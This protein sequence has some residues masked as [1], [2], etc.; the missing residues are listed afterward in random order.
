[1]ITNRERLLQVDSMLE[2]SK[3]TIFSEFEALWLGSNVN[4]QRLTDRSTSAEMAP[5]AIT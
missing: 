3:T 1:M 4:Q 5:A 2:K